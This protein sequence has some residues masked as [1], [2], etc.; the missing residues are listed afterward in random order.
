[1]VLVGHSQRLA[2]PLT[3]RQ[4][5]GMAA[6]GL[7]L[8]LAAIVAGVLSVTNGSGIPASR[9]GC[10]NLVVAGSTGGQVLH[11]CGASARSFCRAEYAR[12][13]GLALK[14]QAQC[15]LAG[16]KRTGAGAPSAG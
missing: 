4:R 7:I 5:R 3:S 12:S 9:D 16:I 10:L 8:V 13:D 14:V 15:G 2:E 11:E 6:V 1:M